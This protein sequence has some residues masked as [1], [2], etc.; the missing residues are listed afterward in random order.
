MPKLKEFQDYFLKNKPVDI[1]IQHPDIQGPINTA[2]LIRGNDILYD[3]YDY[4]EETRMLL[5]KVTDCMIQWLDTVT[6]GVAEDDNG[7]STGAACGKAV[8]VCATVRFS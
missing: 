2:H 1:P 7:Y 8:P 4:P 6:D 5:K 3:F